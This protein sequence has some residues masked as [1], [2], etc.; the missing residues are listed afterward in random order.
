[1]YLRCVPTNLLQFDNYLA[2]LTMVQNHTSYQ[3][4]PS[5]I[6]ILGVLWLIS[7]V[8]ASGQKYLP[9]IALTEYPGSLHWVVGASASCLPPQ[10][11]VD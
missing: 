9:R 5:K 2:G 4:D 6:T 10:F 1:M 8:W 3:G 11:H 7:P